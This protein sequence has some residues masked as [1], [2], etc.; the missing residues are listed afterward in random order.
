MDFNLTGR[1]EALFF[2]VNTTA[3]VLLFFILALPPFLLCLLCVLALMATD[4]SK[5]MR[6]LL[7]NVFVAEICSWISLFIFFLGYPLRARTYAEGIE[8][9]SCHAMISSFVVSTMQ[10]FTAGAIYAVNVYIFIKRGE[11]KL[12]WSIV[13]QYITI[14]WV[15]VTG[16]FG[17]LPYFTFGIINALR[18]LRKEHPL[19]CSGEVT[20]S[21]AISLVIVLVTA[22]AGMLVVIVFSILTWVYIG[23]NTLK[24][25]VRVKKAVAKILI[26][27]T[28]TSILSFLNGIAPT[29]EKCHP[30]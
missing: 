20:I 25:N 23:K 7:I 22:F 24:G 2:A 29:A 12:K 19:F 15:V 21:F 1:D 8:D 5:K 13:V 30:R 17:M 18:T 14:S 3:N 26:Y 10:K 6:V 16:I 27:L 11:K 9:Y 28:V 4:I